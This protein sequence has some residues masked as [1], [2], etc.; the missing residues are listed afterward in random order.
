MIGRGDLVNG[1]Y[2]YKFI[3]ATLQDTV[4]DTNT[5]F[6]NSY[7][8]SNAVSDLVLD[9]HS[10]V[11]LH[12]NN[13]THNAKLWHH[14]LGHVSY[15]VFTLLSNKIPF[16]IPNSYSTYSCD[17]CPL[18]KQKRLPFMSHNTVASDIFELLHCDI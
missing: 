17:I 14:R 15:K 18:S 3:P 5:S 11:S 10:P 13:A 4:P 2:V 7:L 16:S 1:L 9:K 8:H 6:V 12:V